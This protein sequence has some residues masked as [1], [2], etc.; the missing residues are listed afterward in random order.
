MQTGVNVQTPEDSHLGC[1]YLG[2]NLDSWFVKRQPTL[3]RSSAEVEYRRVTD[4][5]S[6]SCW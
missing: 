4:V 1:V 2:D 3:S 6:E 5:V